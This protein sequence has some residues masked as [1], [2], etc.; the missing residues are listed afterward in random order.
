MKSIVARINSPVLRMPE[1]R[2]DPTAIRVVDGVVINAFNQKAV[3][4]THRFAGAIAVEGFYSGPHGSTASFSML[5][6]Y[7]S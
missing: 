5:L 2:I 3:Y 4:C 6:D 7:F 1:T